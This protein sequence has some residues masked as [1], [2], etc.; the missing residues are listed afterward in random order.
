MSRCFA[1]PISWMVNSMRNELTEATLPIMSL[2][3][4]SAEDVPIQNVFPVFWRHKLLILGVFVAV[5][6]L[7]AL[8]IYRIPPYYNSTTVL[9]IDS[10]GIQPLAQLTTGETPQTDMV[11]IKTQV[12]IIRSP[13]LAEGVVSH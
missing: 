8:V 3:S 6:V 2:Q 13:S 10:Q 4:A 1:P 9:L 12:A 5:V 11:A 7:A